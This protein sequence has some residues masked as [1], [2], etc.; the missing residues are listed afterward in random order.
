MVTE[1]DYN[2]GAARYP[3]LKLPYHLF[4]PVNPFQ[5]IEIWQSSLRHPEKLL[6][7]IIILFPYLPQSCNKLLRAGKTILEIYKK[8]SG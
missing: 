8:K 4:G 5:L 6:N 7:F 1:W 2:A 3:F